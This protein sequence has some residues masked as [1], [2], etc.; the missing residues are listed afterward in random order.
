MN[1]YNNTPLTPEILETLLSNGY[2]LERT[3]CERHQN[4]N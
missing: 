2:S 3:D 4:I 1:I